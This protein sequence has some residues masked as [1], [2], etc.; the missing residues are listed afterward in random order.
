MAESIPGTAR[1]GG[2]EAADASPNP[3][4]VE[5]RPAV[6]AW[7]GGIRAMTSGDP[8]GLS[9]YHEKAAKPWYHTIRVQHDDAFIIRP[10]ILREGPF[11]DRKVLVLEPFTRTFRFLHL[12]PE[13]RTMVYE[14]LLEVGTPTIDVT[15]HKPTSLPRRPCRTTF[16]DKELHAPW[17]WDALTGKWIDQPPS[18]ATSLFRINKLIR[19]E[20][21]SI[22]YSTHTFNFY[23]SKDMRLFLETVRTMRQYLRSLRLRYVHRDDGRT[24]RAIFR[25]LENAGDLRT[26]YLPHDLVCR[27]NEPQLG[28]AEL[29]SDSRGL[30]WTLRAA[31]RAGVQG[32][33]PL[34]LFEVDQVPLMCDACA[35]TPAQPGFC[36]TSRRDRCAVSCSGF[37]AH[38]TA[39]TAQ[40]RSEVARILGMEV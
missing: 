22:W 29:L 19:R 37:R 1:D 21:A 26:I 36:W 15:S 16:R 6:Q 14:L 17:E 8:C 27:S 40:I 3:K 7:E 38:C 24:R 11:K 35:R 23:T 10:V 31:Q 2:N 5:P 9:K 4:P 18:S 33:D 34:N 20:S 13:I 39:L 30:L 28:V 12:P 32:I 25:L